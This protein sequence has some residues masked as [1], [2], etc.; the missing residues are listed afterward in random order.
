MK[1]EGLNE[2][3]IAHGQT[4]SIL[5]NATNLA[6]ALG[7]HPSL[8]FLESS[9][10]DF[11][12]IPA[13]L[14]EAN[15]GHLVLFAN[16][17]RMDQLQDESILEERIFCQ[18]T[19]IVDEQVHTSRGHAL[20]A[21]DALGAAIPRRVCQHPFKRND[22]VWV[23][24]T[25]Q[26]D[27]TCVLCHE[28]FKG[29][30]HEGHDVAFYHAQAGGCC[31]CGDPNAWDE[32]GFCSHHG[33]LAVGSG[34][35][36]DIMVDRVRGIVPAAV[37][38]LID[39]IAAQA[40]ESHQRT[41]K[42]NLDAQTKLHLRERVLDLG[43]KEE[44]KMDDNAMINHGHIF[45]PSAASTSRS[46]GDRILN[47]P[48]SRDEWTIAEKL[49][50]LGSVEGGLYLVIHSDDI[51]TNLQLNEAF[52]EFFGKSDFPETLLNRVV[53]NLR[54]HGQ[55]VVWGTYE[56]MCELTAAQ[57]QCWQHGDRVASGQVGALLLDKVSL[58]IKNGIV[59]SVSTRRDLQ[60]E[61]RAVALLDWLTSLARS[62][63]PFCQAVAE[64][65]VPEHLEP[66]L[67]ADFQ[68][69]A[70]IS[71]AW[72][73][74]L[75]TLLAV[76]TFKSHLASAYCDTYQHVTAVYAKGMG[77]LERS[78]YTLS[79]QFL[80]RVTYVVD[81]VQHRDLLGK[82]GRSL[83][84]T[85]AVA[86][87]TYGRLNPNHFC[88]AHR[89]YSPCISDLKCV[90][91]VKG[92]AR[93]FASKAGTFLDDWLTCLSLT[94][95][96]DC[97]VWRI[98]CHG[99]VEFES[100]G[101]V[102]AFNASICLGSL[103]ERLLSWN[104]DDQSP[105]PESSLSHHT[106]SAVDLTLYCLARLTI[107]H[108][109][110][111][112]NYLPTSNS[113]SER[114]Y[115]KCPARLP[116]STIATKHGSPLCLK[117]LPV[118]Q[119][120]PWSF[121]LPLHR[122]VAACVREV[123]R[124]PTNDM[125]ALLQKIREN[126]VEQEEALYEYLMEF[127]LV[128]M[129]RTAQVRSGLWKRNCSG[130]QDQVLNYAE[131]PFCRSLRDADI[132]LLQFSAL[133]RG[134]SDF[135][136]LLLHRFG[137]FDFL[138]FKNA[139]NSS[140]ELY[141]HQVASGLYPK[142]LSGTDD[143][144]KGDVIYP[145]TYTAAN[146]N[147]VG[148]FLPL[149]EEFLHLLIVFLT[150]LPSIPPVDK[151]DHTLQA[152][153]R[154]RREVIHRL[155]SG[156][157]THSELAEVHHVLSHWD[158]ALLSEEGREMNPDDAS[159][160]ALAATLSEVAKK[161]S[162][163]ADMSPHRW[164]LQLT[165]WDHYDPAFFH[166]SG[167]NHQ[168][169]TEYRPKLPT[170]IASKYSVEPRAYACQM[171]H[172]VHPSFYRLQR[173]LT[174]DASLRSILYRTLHVHARTRHFSNTLQGV[175][176]SL[177]YDV[178]GRSEL[179]LARSVQF[180]TLG[181]FAWTEAEDPTN[182]EW[183]QEGG[184]FPGSV[185]YKYIE[186]PTCFDWV[187]EF[188]LADPTLVMDSARYSNEENA[189]Q[190]LL[191]IA[192]GGN[193]DNQY[194]VQDQALRAGAAWLCE[195]AVQRNIEA[196]KLTGVTKV[197]TAESATEVDV[198]S[199]FACRTRAA[200]ARAI[201]KMKS[202]A[203]RFAAMMQLESSEDDS[204]SGA[205]AKA[206]SVR[207]Q[208]GIVKLETSAVLSNSR[209]QAIQDSVSV[210][211][212]SDGHSSKLTR[213]NPISI[214]SAISGYL[215]IK[216][217]IPRRLLVKRPQ[218]I[219]C[220]D[221]SATTPSRDTDMS[222]SR[223]DDDD[224]Q[225]KRS[226]RKTGADALAFVG[227]AQ[228]SAVQKGGGG[229]PPSVDDHSSLSALR[230]F[231]GAH[232]ALCG[233]AVHSECCESYLATSLHREDRIVG[234][235]EEFKC[236]L[237]QRVSNCLV[238]FIDVGAD[239]IETPYCVPVHDTEDMMI[240]DVIERKSTP[241]ILPL[242][243][244]LHDFLTITPWWVGRDDHSVAWDGQSAFVA[245]QVP[246]VEEYGNDNNNT[247]D[248]PLKR[249]RSV[250]SLRKKD[251]CTAWSAMMKTPR[252][253]RRRQLS[254]IKHPSNEEPTV[255]TSHEA[256]PT[257]PSSDEASAGETVVW[258]RFMDLISEMGYRADGKRLGDQNFL[259]YFGEFRHYH[260]EK[261]TYNIAN[262]ASG[263]A[264]VDWPMCLSS[265]PLSDI[266][267]QEL[268]REKLLAKLL[269]TI[270]SFTYSCCAEAYEAKRLFRKELLFTTE[271]DETLNDIQK[272]FSTYG[273]SDIVCDGMLVS[274]P[275]PSIEDD[276]TQP[277]NGRLGK[278]RYTGLAL[279]AATG[280]VSADLVQLVLGLPLSSDTRDPLSAQV[281]H[282]DVPFRAPVVFPILMGHV[283]T[284]V[285]AAMCAT[286]GRARARSDFLELAW[287]VPF[288]KRGSFC[289]VPSDSS[290]MLTKSIIIDCLGF[291][292]LGLLARILQALLGTLQIEPG[293]KGTIQGVILIKSFHQYLQDISG[294]D[295]HDDM[296][297]WMEGCCAILE[298]SFTSEIRSHTNCSGFVISTDVTS[299]FHTAC[300]V[301]AEVAA[302]YLSDIGVVLQILVP[303]ALVRQGTKA[304]SLYGSHQNRDPVSAVNKL[305]EQLELER[306]NVMLDS[307]LT[308]HVIANWF[309]SSC[310]HA[311][312]VE[313]ANITR[314]LGTV[315]QS[316]LL[317]TEGFRV[318]DWPLANCVPEGTDILFKEHAPWLSSSSRNCS[319][320]Q[321][322]SV[323][324]M[325]VDSCPT[326]MQGVRG[327]TVSQTPASLVA[328]GTKKSVSLLGGFFDEHIDKDYPRPRLFKLPT[329]YTDLYAELAG[330]CP[331]CEQIALCLV[332]GEVLNANGKG[333]CTRHS[334]KCGAGATIFFLLQECQ[335]LIMH[336]DKAAYVQSPYV[337]SHGE[338]PQFR[339][340]PLNLD[341]D[342]Y[343]I[344]RELWSGHSVRQKVVKER[345]S[346]RQVIIADF[347]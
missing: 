287:P 298:S 193:I 39:Q 336:G 228:S 20:A 31:D 331:D 200:K 99:P 115:N 157:K 18:L 34:G 265:S 122:F 158:N 103:F 123:C 303:G 344:F 278:L 208:N 222:A 189:L 330:L 183:R 272:V 258:R 320:P 168:S 16:F 88:L 74:L 6:G 86:A 335:G 97:Q 162:N 291:I 255:D 257:W 326:H 260:V 292:K 130:M 274:F 309:R 84:E 77:V 26:A 313:T 214:P 297:V 285:V 49:G 195:F 27:E 91:N 186:A 281:R 61:Q 243:T 245:A 8:V 59:C 51:H 21:L 333:E 264:I 224:G 153:G 106:Q 213:T 267:R 60:W 194:K 273:I 73:S 124:R 45:L 332:C 78:G 231:T 244:S 184:N 323:T 25:C 230:R 108:V 275:A 179:A 177:A 232:V 242:Q 47:V 24:R 42:Q 322:D 149:L 209:T 229:L 172:G 246:Y 81:L 289:G 32:S 165:A 185:F 345:E 9:H 251:L 89:R 4:T 250:R 96:M 111:V 173:D 64:S 315:A 226:R 247:L 306:L 163:R 43:D 133:G 57:V 341:L 14:N 95:F 38:W 82:L 293:S 92:M 312:S 36:P 207:P 54:I 310:I 254:R 114:D 329:S 282:G 58:L 271:R 23:C 44:S 192:D 197:S 90:L 40:L 187:H 141:R 142:E 136:H 110:E 112:P 308:R 109:S 143:D 190:L 138:G 188:L 338:T 319:E 135:V 76:P 152:K 63:D 181:A 161:K 148:T 71:K 1:K 235:R 201:G 269:L 301:A 211:V 28:C 101:W 170:N 144:D 259:Q 182:S 202:Q 218:C 300:E 129:A 15:R 5:S 220:N 295:I 234:R 102:G 146:Y 13:A 343:D 249:R 80:N 117:A 237:C 204:I 169:A 198:E 238:P 116:F 137:L 227:Y 276:G 121:H 62:C 337:D 139:P 307:S 180:L 340:R 175:R 67:K 72:H 2:M 160:A 252:F 154:L 11:E 263:K 100:R 17:E 119:T 334:F 253:M 305:L 174:A 156:P 166:M 288:N 127:P 83:K 120:T 98:E 277:F 147:D 327:G 261:A 270:Q 248:V 3:M 191:R 279:M 75:L 262:R 37:E 118:A 317:Q 236:P 328:F 316:R 50:K 203:D 145:W 176:G 53:K 302:S 346:L 325:E 19:Q 196:A 104:D 41:K 296:K 223:S 206:T 318:L 212:P 299:R 266:R 107:W 290:S 178:E 48:I 225:R 65:I 342:R 10:D 52:H 140:K 164:E 93:L 219:I 113:T 324:P 33:L 105:A 155:A 7:S 159:G 150:E 29:S 30:N 46:R 205:A 70:R 79:V 294:M 151:I 87:G 240:E 215:D 128:V 126:S 35:L 241:K 268:S 321:H 55:L 347:Y 131:P 125:E 56:L 216:Q 256:L 283:L 22:I 311:E 284:H 221:D 280:A 217:M 94:Q 233:H 210:L 314:G 286:C 134:T 304:R 85:L 199:E 68:L 339:G 171:T 132:L 12:D 66:M 239:W 69:S 167:S